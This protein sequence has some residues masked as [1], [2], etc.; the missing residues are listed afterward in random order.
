MLSAELFPERVEI[1]DLGGELVEKGWENVCGTLRWFCG[2][3]PE[4]IEHSSSGMVVEFSLMML[5]A[6]V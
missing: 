4:D 3:G 1:M 5:K 6:V 2:K